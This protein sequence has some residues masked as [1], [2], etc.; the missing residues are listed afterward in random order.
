MKNNRFGWLTVGLLLMLLIVPVSKVAAEIEPNQQIMVDTDGRET[1]TKVGFELMKETIGSLAV[2]MSADEI[3]SQL[4]M[5]EEKSDAQVWG[6]DG[7]EHQ[8]W[9][10]PTKGVELGMIKREGKQGVEKIVIKDSCEYKTQRGIKIGSSATNIHAAYKNV[11]NPRDSK[12]GERIVCGTVYGG[13]I[14]KLQNDIVSTIFIGAAA[15]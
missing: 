6:A 10:Y 11:I 2:G 14:F 13:I 4:G 7:M 12:P 8:R 1:Y 9:Y 3:L 5:P 15:E